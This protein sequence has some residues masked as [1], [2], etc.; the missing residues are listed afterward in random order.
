MRE[1]TKPNN[2]SEITEQ[3]HIQKALSFLSKKENPEVDQ[4]A[5]LKNELL[6]KDLLI[7][8]LSS[9]AERSRRISAMGELATTIAH[10]VRNPLGTI[11]IYASLLS[12]EL[13]QD[14]AKCEYSNHISDEVK[15]LDL[16]LNNL[17]LFA[18]EI[19]IHPIQTNLKQ[20]LINALQDAEPLFY[21]KRLTIETNLIEMTFLA[22]AQLLTQMILNILLNAVQ[23]IDVGGKINIQMVQNK[24]FPRFIQIIIGD[25]GSGIAQ[26]HIDSIFNPFFTT[27]S[28]GTGLGLTNAHNIVDAHGGT[29]EVISE[30]KK[31]TE[32]RV[33]LPTDIQDKNKSFDRKDIL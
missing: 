25:N 15:R 14:E 7:Q 33:L 10:K 19:K 22:D 29:I 28:S 23:A 24:L 16:I 12:R 27:K 6:Q 4:I 3:L 13:I 5:H 32:V 26:K 30:E 18:R 1:Q 20:I 8:K 9:H 21:G 2:N 11:S 17:L 31:G